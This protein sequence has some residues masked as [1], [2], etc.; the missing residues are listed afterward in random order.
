LKEE[1]GSAALESKKLGFQ[2]CYLVGILGVSAPRRKDAGRSTEAGVVRAPE[3]GC[4][5]EEE[6]LN[7]GLVPES[8]HDRGSF[9]SYQKRTIHVGL[10][11]GSL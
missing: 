10:A 6:T 3:S 11:G 8:M 7:R 2:K 1:N 4:F 5:F 9:Q